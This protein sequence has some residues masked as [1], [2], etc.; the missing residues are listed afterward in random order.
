MNGQES[1]Q[2]AVWVH[3]AVLFWVYTAK[4]YIKDF[5]LLVDNVNSNIVIYKYAFSWRRGY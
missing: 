2:A 4:F 5:T 3:T 1:K